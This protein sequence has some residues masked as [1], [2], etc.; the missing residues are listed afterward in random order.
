ML[1]GG[2]LPRSSTKEEEQEM[3]QKHLTTNALLAAAAA[4]VVWGAN[5]TVATAT[6]PCPVDFE[7]PVDSE[8][9]ECKVLIEI[10]SSD[11]DIGF[12]LLM[13]GDDLL[14]A[15]A[16]DPSG[17]KIFEES[18]KGPLTE[19]FLTE[20]FFE[21]AE[22][23]CWD[24]LEAD[25]DDEIVT[26]EDFL[27]RWED[28]IYSFH[29]QGEQGE[30]SEGETVLTYDLPA[31]PQNLAF[32]GSVISWSAGD[33][34]GECASSAVLGALVVEDV[35]T[36][37]PQDVPVDRWEVVFDPADGSK[38]T[39]RVPGGIS[40]MQVTVPADYLA[41]LPDDTPAKIEVGAI[42]GED[43][44]TFTEIGGFCINE[45]EGCEEED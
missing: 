45:V 3:K 10:N 24:D 31:A 44:A 39:V 27:D 30:K 19:Q 22:P 25:L 12:H 21:S 32:D 11:G 18:A 33:D 2:C 14:M 7:F 23:L 34:L 8:F 36:T 5:T 6:A 35:L 13:D 28:G 4:V 41:S 43:N 37:H 42:G 15:T 26:L 9:G 38:Y 20:T 1:T 29:G 40:P 16:K 17:Q